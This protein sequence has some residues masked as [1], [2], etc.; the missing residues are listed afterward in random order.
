M[1]SG[2]SSARRPITPRMFSSTRKCWPRERFGATLMTPRSPQVERRGRV[3][4]DP[5]GALER[6][7][8]QAG[9]RE[10]MEDDSAGEALE[11]RGGRLVGGAR[12]DDDGLAEIRGQGEL[13]LEQRELAVARCVVAVEVEPGLAHGDGA[14]GG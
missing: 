13:G 2:A 12:V 14:V 1:S 7:V 10:A 9:R 3:R 5:R 6:R 11:G 8:E 4:V